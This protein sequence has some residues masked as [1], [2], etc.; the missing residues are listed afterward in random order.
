MGGAICIL[1]LLAK[2][3]Y[4]DTNC[5]YRRERYPTEA[6]HAHNGQS[7]DGNPEGEDS[8]IQLLEG[9]NVVRG[10]NVE[11]RRGHQRPDNERHGVPHVEA[12]ETDF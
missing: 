8:Q 12:P 11:A 5:H 10:Q 1:L 3:F 2:Q 9:D 7:S 6:A 4:N